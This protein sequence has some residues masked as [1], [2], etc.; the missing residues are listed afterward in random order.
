MSQNIIP[1]ENQK[2]AN[3]P[4]KAALPCSRRKGNAEL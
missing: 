3:N 4:V 2:A 1:E